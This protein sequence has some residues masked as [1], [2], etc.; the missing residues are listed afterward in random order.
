MIDL[1]EDHFSP[2][3]GRN[4]VLTVGGIAGT[5]IFKIAID[6]CM[7]YHPFEKILVVDGCQDYIGLLRKPVPNYIHY[8][9]LFRSVRIPAIEEQLRPM[10]TFPMELK[11][12]YQMELA[13]MLM[14]GYDA[15]IINNAHLIPST[16]RTALAKYFP[17]YVLEI[18]DPLD[19]N[20]T[21]F[22]EVPTLHDTLAKQSPLIAMARSMYGVD[23]RAID[24]KVRG[25]FKK[26]K[27]TKRG[28][29]KI[30]ANQYVTNS[31]D[32]LNQIQS[33]QLSSQ[34]RRNQ[35]FVVASEELRMMNDQDNLPVVV[36]PGTMLSITTASKPLMKL[37]IHSSTRQVYSTL[38]YTYTEKALY[39]KPANIIMADDACHHRFNSI[40]IVLGEEPMT[41]R[42][43]YSL[44]KI[45]NTITI[46]DF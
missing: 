21:D 36:G 44:L 27:M 28:I 6:A 23:T 5:K 11:S 2:T 24:R 4:H 19:F 30:D 32:V 18:I 39:V 22:H 10:H 9:D 25:D 20:G 35:K 15:L 29:G 41:N 3:W 17:G 12:G 7:K 43:W 33:K 34:F 37:R 46:V 45:A 31:Y 40:V 8:M 13:D 1:I 14:R 42:L 38:S 26:V 16:C